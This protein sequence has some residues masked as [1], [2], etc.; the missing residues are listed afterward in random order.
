MQLR[1]S[2]I[3]ESPEI[4]FFGTNEI[5]TGRFI[6][7][8]RELYA[9]YSANTP[10]FKGDGAGNGWIGKEFGAVA[11]SSIG[12]YDKGIV[13]FI[14]GIKAGCT[15]RAAIT[16]CGYAENVMPPQQR[17][18]TLV[19]FYSFHRNVSIVNP[20]S[21]RTLSVTVATSSSIVFGL[22]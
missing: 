15:P 16:H 13:L 9:A 5:I 14:P 20:A 11:G 18:Y 7:Y 22:L 12:C 1:K 19:Q 10:C 17:L 2:S 4:Y 6:D 21:V 8:T 3:R